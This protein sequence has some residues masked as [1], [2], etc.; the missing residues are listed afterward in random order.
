MTNGFEKSLVPMSQRDSD[1]WSESTKR[2][3]TPMD[4]SHCKDTLRDSTFSS[5]KS[6][7]YAPLI[8]KLPYR[9]KMTGYSMLTYLT[10]HDD[11][12]SSSPKP[13]STSSSRAV[14]VKAVQQS[15][16]EIDVEAKGEE[17]ILV[18][19]IWE[20]TK[21]EW[22]IMISLAFISLM[23]ALDATILVTV[24]PVSQFSRKSPQIQ[25]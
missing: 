6:T 1:S 11:D 16:T 19:E 21:N 4:P 13:A 7:C 23:V 17:T 9:D 25:C 14:S 15:S 2:V 8:L 12:T 10:A 24:L 18:V 3:S 20:P 5:S 22:L